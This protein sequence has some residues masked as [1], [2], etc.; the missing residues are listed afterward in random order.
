MTDKKYPSISCV[1]IGLNSGRTL[2]G[3]LNAIKKADYPNIIEIIYVDGGSSDDSV[4][5]ARNTGSVTVI[6]LNLE[7]PTPGR[8][9]NAGWQAARSEWAQFLDSDTRVDPAWF[10]QAVQGINDRTAAVYGYRK[11]LYPDKNRYHFVADLE[12]NLDKR[13]FGGDVLIRREVLE[14]TCGYREDLRRGEDPELA[15]RIRGEGHVIKRLPVLMCLHDINMTRF[16]QYLRRCFLSGYAYAGACF[17]MAKNGYYN[18][19]KRA[20]KITIKTAG[21]VFFLAAAVIYKNINFFFAAVILNI[22][23]ILKIPL[24]RKRYKLTFRK[25]ALYALHTILWAYPA[26]AGIFRYYFGRLLNRPWGEN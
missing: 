10:Q 11:E 4:S 13:N 5:I 25:S 1:I 8:Q 15:V 17:P 22:M 3:C 24:F 16:T 20:A 14:E 18:W 23:P 9:R 2:A 12:W 26:A 6:E 21:A 7:R 19:L